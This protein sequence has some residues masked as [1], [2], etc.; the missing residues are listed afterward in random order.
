[1]FSSPW[2][3]LLW[4][5]VDSFSCFS[6]VL[7]LYSNHLLIFGLFVFVDEVLV[8]STLT[9]WLVCMSCRYL[10]FS[11]KDFLPWMGRWKTAY[12]SVCWG[13][14]TVWHLEIIAI[15]RVRQIYMGEIE[16]AFHLTVPHWYFPT[17]VLL[18]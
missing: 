7:L 11:P 17:C 12:R 8:W 3:I 10:Y 1:M 9:K 14:E 16:A 5:L 18:F 4:G 6:F 15:A 2:I 13:W